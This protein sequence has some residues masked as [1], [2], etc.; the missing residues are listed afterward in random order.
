MVNAYIER[1]YVCNE[2]ATILTALLYLGVETFF[3]EERSHRYYADFWPHLPY[4]NCDRQCVGVEREKSVL[5]VSLSRGYNYGTLIYAQ[6]IILN[7]CLQ[8]VPT[9]CIILGPDIITY[10]TKVIWNTTQLSI[11]CQTS[12]CHHRPG[13]SSQLLHNVWWRCWK[14]TKSLEESTL[15]RTNPRISEH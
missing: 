2:G 8:D 1:E 12:A 4:L 13:Q 10:L 7:Q 15:Q 5:T 3:S 11:N 14:K 9:S 6:Y